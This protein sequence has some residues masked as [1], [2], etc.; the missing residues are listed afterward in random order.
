ML[1]RSVR[2]FHECRVLFLGLAF[3]L[4]DGCHTSSR[5]IETIDYEDIQYVQT[6]YKINQILSGSAHVSIELDSSDFKI[7]IADPLPSKLF[8]YDI[9]RDSLTETISHQG[10]VVDEPFWFIN[11]GNYIVQRG[12]EYWGKRQGKDYSN[13]ISYLDEHQRAPTHQDFEVLDN[14]SLFL[15]IYNYN[16]VGRKSLTDYAPFHLLDSSGNLLNVNVKIP[17]IYGNG[18]LIEDV[19]YLSSDNGNVLISYTA[20]DTVYSVGQN[21]QVHH[22]VFPTR[23]DSNLYRYHG[24]TSVQGKFKNRMYN[25][26]NGSFY[27]PAFWDEKR[28][29]VLRLFYEAISVKGEIK[30]KKVILLVLNTQ[31][32]Q[33]KSVV[34]GSF[35][36]P[37]YYDWNYT[38]GNLFA[39]RYALHPSSANRMVERFELFGLGE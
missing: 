36:N 16:Y 39:L 9:N 4:L 19:H 27:G 11:S 2:M 38:N 14:G 3:I 24:D 15:F 7:W 31:T 26:S 10:R 25:E 22:W 32:H 30:G 17:D 37:D 29:C 1:N 6:T 13:R 18:G 23:I 8:V 35:R 33:T 28:R 5:N 20:T 12:V 34:L 21:G